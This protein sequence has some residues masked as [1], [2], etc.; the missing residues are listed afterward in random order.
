MPSIRH[1]H[2]AAEREHAHARSGL[3]Q[4]S[5]TSATVP[6]PPSRDDALEA[7]DH[8]LLASSVPWPGALGAQ[9]L[10]VDRMA[11]EQ[12]ADIVY[13][14]A[15]VVRLALR[16]ATG[17]MIRQF[18]TCGSLPQRTAPDHHRV[19]RHDAPASGHRN[20]SLRRV[21]SGSRTGAPSPALAAPS[22][23]TPPG[24]GESSG[25][26]GV[27]GRQPAVDGKRTVP[28]GPG[29][30]ILAGIGIAL[31]VQDVKQ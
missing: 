11:L 9:H 13:A 20:D 22:R 10:G 24:A 25:R 28:P 4:P 1:V 6:S 3:D 31:G 30:C 12:R 5:A 29:E 26:R 7:I 15:F 8:G 16:P 23:G 17:L 2:D 14:E 27:A 18:R 19:A 21:P